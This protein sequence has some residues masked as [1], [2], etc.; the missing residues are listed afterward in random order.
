MFR[1][2]FK[3]NPNLQLWE[4]LFITTYIHT[5]IQKCVCTSNFLIVISLQIFSMT[6]IAQF[7]KSL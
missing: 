6:D 7:S 1:Y 4:Y 3:K 5:H 2:K